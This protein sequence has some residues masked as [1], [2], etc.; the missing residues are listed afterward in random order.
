MIFSLERSGRPSVDGGALLWALVGSLFL[1]IEKNRHQFEKMM[2]CWGGA[3]R[4]TIL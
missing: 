1:L 4:Y 3:V 2:T